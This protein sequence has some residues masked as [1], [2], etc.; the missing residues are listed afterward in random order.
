M[1]SLSLIDVICKLDF[2][3]QKFLY[4]VAIIVIG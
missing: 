4:D 2:V 3:T 1:Q